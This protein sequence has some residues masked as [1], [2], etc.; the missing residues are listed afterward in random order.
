MS[1]N[2]SAVIRRI[3]AFTLVELLIVMAIATLLAA[4]SLTTVKGLLKDQKLS[5]AAR[6]AKQYVDT[7]RTRAMANGR[8]VALFLERVS[9]AGA[10]GVPVEANYTVTRMSIGEVFPPYTGETAGATARL[11]DMPIAPTRPSDGFADQARMFA[12][13]VISA[14]GTATSPGMVSVGDSIEFVGNEQRFVIES[15][16]YVGT[17]VAV[18]FFNPPA[19]YDQVLGTAR[20][21]LPSYGD[22]T[23]EQSYSG[24]EPTL[25]TSNILASRLAASTTVSGGLQFRVYRKPTKSMVGAITLPRGTCIDLSVSGI[26][27]ASTAADTFNPFYLSG[28]PDK[29]VPSG[30]TLQPS[31]FSRIAIVFNAEGKPTGM[32]RDDRIISLTSSGTGNISTVFTP[33]GM[34]STLHLMVGRTNQVLPS[35]PMLSPGLGDRD[36]TKANLM[37]SANTWISINPF[38]G[39]ID[40]SPVGAVSSTTLSTAVEQARA[41]AIRGINDGGR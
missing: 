30:E 25:K 40:S 6:L 37:D 31:S 14:F 29:N 8:P 28:S 9:A 11:Y 24:R 15:I 16:E 32:F 22:P 13:D 2:R 41:F 1:K 26:G 39:A 18:T 3:A 10:A 35:T 17:E 20:L 5:Q 34:S 4:L 27:P 38:T 23:Y 19:T 33:F 21:A 7:A 12:A 36:P